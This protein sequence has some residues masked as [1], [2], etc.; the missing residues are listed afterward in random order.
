MA[1]WP[2]IVAG[3]KRLKNCFWKGLWCFGGM[4]ALPPNPFRTVAKQDAKVIQ[5]DWNCWSEH[6]CVNCPVSFSTKTTVHSARPIFFKKNVPMAPHRFHDCIKPPKI[7][8]HHQPCIVWSLPE[9]QRRCRPWPK[10]RKCRHWRCRP[11]LCRVSL[12]EH[13]QGGIAK[14]WIKA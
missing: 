7:S 5:T 14:I 1:A 3:L 6:N 12:P 4:R 8:D 2:L 9:I 13:R 10:T 11:T